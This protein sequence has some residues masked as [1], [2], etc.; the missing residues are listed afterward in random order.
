M[1]DAVGGALEVFILAGAKRPEEY[2]EP[3][4]AEG[5]AEQHEA[6]HRGHR[7][8]RLRRKLFSMTVI[9]EV[10]IAAAATQGVTWPDAA[11]GSM[12]AL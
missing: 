1:K 8:L 6:E 12:S 11:R 7:G 3:C 10:D 5:E 9:D 2:H 4:A